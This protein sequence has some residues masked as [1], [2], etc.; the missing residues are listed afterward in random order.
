MKKK[1]VSVYCHSNCEL[2]YENDGC[3]AWIS[4]KKKD[5]KTASGYEKYETEKD[6]IDNVCM[7]CEKYTDRS[8]DRKDKVLRELD[9]NMREIDRLNSINSELYGIV[10]S[11]KK[12][13]DKK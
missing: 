8:E 10:R 9:K 11:I 2:W 6:F 4:F 5:V 13:V 12:T 1:K 3:C 7:Y